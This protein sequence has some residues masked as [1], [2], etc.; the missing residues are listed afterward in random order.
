MKYASLPTRLLQTAV[1]LCGIT[2]VYA[3]NLLD[4]Y[5]QTQA[6]DTVWAGARYNYEASIEKYPQGRALLLPSVIFNAGVFK[7][8][9]DKSK[10]TSDSVPF[11]VIKSC[12]M[13][14]DN[15]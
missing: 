4:I 11:I 1:M 2:P 8:S 15:F 10:P 12:H 9:V 3:D 6:S 13:Y 14:M 5:H 7:N